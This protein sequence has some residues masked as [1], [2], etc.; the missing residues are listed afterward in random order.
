MFITLPIDVIALCH[1]T[2]YGHVL[3][4]IPVYDATPADIT[5]FAAAFHFDA[6]YAG[7]AAT[8]S[9]AM[10]P[11]LFITPLFSS[12]PLRLPLLLLRFRH[13]HAADTP[14]ACCCRAARRHA[15]TLRL[16]LPASAFMRAP[17]ILY[18]RYHCYV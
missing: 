17:I 14:F 12:S 10:P 6:D 3:P 15:F 1:H 11:A 16:L 18:L 2:R 9:Y 4:M 7:A 13:C 5:L 8:L